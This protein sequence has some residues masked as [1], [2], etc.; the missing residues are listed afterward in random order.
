[1]CGSSAPRAGRKNVRP[2]H[3]RSRGRRAA[4]AIPA[5]AAKAK[6][7][8]DAG[9]QQVGGEHD[10][11]PVPSVDV[12]AGDEADGEVGDRL[13]DGHER[14]R[15]VEPV[16]SLMTRRTR[17]RVIPSPMSETDLAA[18]TGSG[19]R[20][21][22]DVA[23]A[24]R[25]RGGRHRSSVAVL[26]WL[27]DRSATT[28]PYSSPSASSRSSISLSFS[29]RR[30]TS[31]AG[32][33]SRACGRREAHPPPLEVLGVGVDE[34]GALAG[35]DLF[36]GLLEHASSMPLTAS[37]R[38][39][40]RAGNARPGSCGRRRYRFSRMPDTTRVSATRMKPCSSSRPR[41]W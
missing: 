25:C 2:T 34:P 5:L 6:V 29:M 23:D 14:E 33:G 21:A 40:R 18:R 41:W 10:R 28:S 17:R 32:R 39:R 7:E 38:R 22:E 35:Q 31:Y 27:G 19:S 36:P 30:M 1:M 12:H 9:A 13:G 3:W 37:R 16:S 4:A 8:H 26:R 15:G 11:A 24:H 20:D